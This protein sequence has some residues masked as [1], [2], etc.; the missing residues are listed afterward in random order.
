[1]SKVETL[2]S[3]AQEASS[4]A[5]T[6]FKRYESEATPKEELELMKSLISE[7]KNF[8]EE[9]ELLEQHKTLEDVLNKSAKPAPSLTIEGND[10]KIGKTEKSK[11]EL[12][13]T[14]LKKGTAGFETKD[15]N[16]IQ[17][18]DGGIVVPELFQN[19]VILEMQDINKLRNLVQVHAIDK[20]STLF[21][22]F[23]MD[24]T[25]PHVAENAAMAEE[26][27][28]GSF[29][30]KRFTPYLKARMYRLSKL[31][32]RD[33]SID[34]QG[35][36][37]NRFAQ[38]FAEVEEDD[39]INGSGIKEPLGLLNATFLNTAPTLTIA[40]WT[41]AADSNDV[42]AALADCVYGLREQYRRNCVW[43]MSRNTLGL[44][45]KVVDANNQPLFQPSLQ[46]GQPATLMGYPV[47]EV[48]TFAA[49]ANSGDAFAIFGDL[50]Q[51]L[52]V[53]R[54]GM[55]MERTEEGEDT[56]KKH[57][58]LFKMGREYD[59]DIVDGNAFIRLNVT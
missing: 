49:A 35:L 51:Y 41:T 32:I 37:A 55:I 3:K 34:V 19:Q 29:G 46:A 1:M 33:A 40:N 59:G 18:D 7:A 25:L 30:E 24:P 50:K 54:S 43:V 45:R 57:Q 5:E 23:D 6:I 28:D 36:I 42:N 48:E 56:F 52:L 53:E 4:K 27:M 9:A 31:F 20:A 47:Y 21:P 44:C 38:R 8:L 58:V 15:L 13:E 39:I 12:F 16:R 2:R 10:G 14:F 11:E 26:D 17:A 22:V